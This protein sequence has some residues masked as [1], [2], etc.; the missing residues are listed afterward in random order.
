M[1][2]IAFFFLKLDTSIIWCYIGNVTRMQFLYCL[3][4]SFTSFSVKIASICWREKA[5]SDAQNIFREPNRVCST[6]V[7]QFL[8]HVCL[9]VIN[10]PRVEYTFSSFSAIFLWTAGRILGNASLLYCYGPLVGSPTFKTGPLDNPLS[11]T[12]RKSHTE[13]YKVNREFVPVRW[14]SSQPVTAKSTT[15]LVSL[16]YR[17]TQMFDNNPPNTVI[18]HN[19]HKPPALPTRRWPQCCWLKASSTWSLHLLLISLNLLCH[20]NTRTRNMVSFLSTCWSISRTWDVGFFPTGPKISSQL[21]LQCLKMR[22]LKKK[23]CK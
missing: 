12:Q 8:C 20:S 16:L 2:V 19:R 17:H 9:K 11:L 5:H 3:I 4:I 6:V 15:H 1:F 22:N 14:W 13:Q 10:P 18:F 7:T 21:L 23:R